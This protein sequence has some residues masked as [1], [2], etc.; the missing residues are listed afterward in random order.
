MKKEIIFNNFTR[1]TKVQAPLLIIL[2]VLCGLGAYYFFES[3]RN[4]DK[5]N[6]RLISGL[7]GVV[8]IFL[9]C[10]DIGLVIFSLEHQPS[11]TD[12]KYYQ[13]TDIPVSKFSLK[14]NEFK[15]KD[16][17]V[18]DGSKDEVLIESVNTSLKV[19]STK[20]NLKRYQLKKE[21]YEMVNI[22][23]EIYY[24]DITKPATEYN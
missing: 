11:I 21:W 19:K 12:P 18:I 7:V 13:E 24:V 10:F 20:A 2:M 3:T 5:A 14:D 22:P 17:K 6:L 23:K 16:G 15:T 9:I 1:S 4:K 8:S